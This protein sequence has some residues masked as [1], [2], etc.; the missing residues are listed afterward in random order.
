MT[1]LD[2]LSKTVIQVVVMS[3]IGAHTGVQRRAQEQKVLWKCNQYQ[4]L[5]KWKFYQ[6]S[7]ETQIRHGGQYICEII[8]NLFR[9]LQCQKIQKSIDI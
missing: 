8:E 4:L 5:N 7:V 2:N 3:S 1:K 9:C 6:G